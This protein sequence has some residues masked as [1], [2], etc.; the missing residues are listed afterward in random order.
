MRLVL[1]SGSYDVDDDRQRVDLDALWQFLGS[2]AYWARW[3]TR[4]DV[5][6]QVA[7]AWRVVGCYSSHGEMVGFARAVSDGVD[8]AYL[9]DVYVL[10]DHRGQ[11]LAAAMLSELIDHGPGSV[12]RWLLHTADAHGLYRRFGFTEPDASLMERRSPRQVGRQAR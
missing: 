2:E 7:Q 5:V 3:R 6:Q 12:F 10:P 8:I 1:A 4:D 9:A 11:G